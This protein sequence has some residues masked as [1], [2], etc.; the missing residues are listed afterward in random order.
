[1]KQAGC[2]PHGN[3]VHGSFTNVQQTTY[4]RLCS[5]AAS[6]PLAKD[7]C[8]ANIPAQHCTD[9]QNSTL[10]GMRA[11]EFNTPN[12]KIIGKQHKV[13]SWMNIGRR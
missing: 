10:H 12:G 1:M 4:G 8:K 13:L 3:T 5:P 9:Q 6:Q 11:Q 7:S 2:R